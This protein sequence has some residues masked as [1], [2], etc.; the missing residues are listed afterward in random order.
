[1]ARGQIGRV[2]VVVFLTCTLAMGL[3]QQ[4]PVPESA[5]TPVFRSG[6]SYIELDA[7]V[8]DRD[9][10][11]V[12]GLTAGDFTV[13]EDGQPQK[14][15][16]FT[17]IN[18]PNPEPVPVDWMR[19]VT[20]DVQANDQSVDE[21]LVV[22]FMDD[23]QAPSGGL[24]RSR[25]VAKMLIDRLG[26][27][28]RAA[29]VFARLPGSQ[30]FTNDHAKLQ[31]S[32]NR[33]ASFTPPGGELDILENTI[34]RLG[35]IA[36]NLAALPGKRKALFYF[37]VGVRM[38][39]PELDPR[40]IRAY[41]DLIEVFREAERANVNIYPIDPGGLT[42][43]DEFSAERS[44]S[45]SA[46]R[47][48]TA[49]TEFYQAVAENTGGLALVNRNDFASA[50]PRILRENGSYYL[51][52]YQSPNLKADGKLR[53]IS[54]KVNRPGMTVRAR[55]GYFGAK[56]DAPAKKT[57]APTGLSAAMETAAAGLLQNAAIRMQVATAAFAVPQKPGASVAITAGIA[58]EP[59]ADRSQMDEVS[60]LAEAFTPDGAKAG[61]V[62]Q[63]FRIGTGVKQFELPAHLELKPGRYQL[64]VSAESKLRGKAGS[65][66]TDLEVP[67]F[68]R[69]LSMSGVVVHAEPGVAAPSD[70]G[71]VPLAPL[72]P[73]TL[74]QFFGGQ[75][76]TAFLRVYQGGSA[77][78][79]EVPLSVH[80][81]DVRNK[82]VFEASQ[83]LKADRFNAA[84]AAEYR[85]ALPVDKL[86]EGA[87]L[88]TIEAR[89][90]KDTVRRDVRFQVQELD[91]A[92]PGT[93][94]GE[95]EVRD[96]ALDLVL[97]RMSAYLSAYADQ[98]SSTIA[99][100]RYT[101][102]YGAGVGSRERVLES[103]FGIVRLPG[104][105]QWLAFRDV[106]RVDGKTVAD[107]AGRL[108]ALF[109]NASAGTLKQADKIT[110][111]S[112]RFNIGP[113]SRTVNNPAVLL[114][115]LDA[116]NQYRFRFSK[117]GEETLDGTHAWVLRFT[118]HARPTFIRSFKGENEPLIGRAW[119]DP[120]EGRLLRVEITI[121]DL[122][123]PLQ[124]M[125][126]H[127]S[128]IITVTFRED[129]RLR[130]WVPATMT[131]RYDRLGS[132]GRL[133]TG[134]ATYSDYRRFGVETKEELAKE[135]VK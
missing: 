118:E 88:L 93:T 44:G 113:I 24:N 17:E 53:A 57:A 26:P 114:E 108:A 89:L 10:N 37:G 133:A 116:R 8:L 18:V 45:P 84:R 6:I 71:T 86:V 132:T 129:P 107:R 43:V 19:D 50:V 74:R 16:S 27:A 104:N 59:L 92:A 69:P 33:F 76:V 34:V 25:E 124:P 101:Q 126:P 72:T 135:D 127:F 94:T 54:V 123:F 103:D 47:S 97:G 4:A 75:Q 66:F 119:V 61:S 90:K 36:T 115:A 56:A 39:H 7:S 28:D 70:T 131:E 29:V 48:L 78:I 109:Q 100:E 40:E 58:P 49:S 65:V 95:S 21:R 110:Q 87:Y 60:L 55:S 2:A 11:P 73:T 22:I 91:W 80:I 105:S 85:I 134:E 106:I 99:T 42:G 122:F 64:R 38:P 120:A 121:P 9:R 125:T 12:H 82:L 32:I 1:M 20:P 98:Y 35:D 23:G 111:E 52:G 15:L 46:P 51:L 14:I 31:A 83:N 63:P 30:D 68:S 41:N 128:A 79:A 102:S 96:P 67:D 62:F 112:T 130:L 81:R 13:L 117:G 5:T 77:N 3:A